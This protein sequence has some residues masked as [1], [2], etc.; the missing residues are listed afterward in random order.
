[1]NKLHGFILLSLVCMAIQ[2]SG[3]SIGQTPPVTPAAMEEGS[4][5]GGTGIIRY[6]DDEGG[7]GFGGT[8]IIGNIEAFGSIWVNGI[9]ID[10]DEKVAI[11][12]NLTGRDQKL[13]LGQ[14]VILETNLELNQQ[15]HPTTELITIYYPLAG[16]IQEIE[17]GRML[18]NDEWILISDKTHFDDGLTLAIGEYAAISAIQN[19]EQLWLASRLDLNPHKQVIN[20]PAVE[21]EFS[22]NIQQVLIDE[23]LQYIQSLWRPRHDF[24]SRMKKHRIPVETWNTRQR[25]VPMNMPGRPPVERKMLQDLPRQFNDIRDI[26]RMMK[27]LPPRGVP[28]DGFIRHFHR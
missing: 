14:S 24:I 27:H 6:V 17:E 5:F 2:L 16:K 26:P 21:V 1:M 3:C 20:Q 11:Q 10:Y 25:F 23:R 7:S 28:R 12:S 9:E 4:G 15:N 18:V 13:K 22:E 8:G 19:E